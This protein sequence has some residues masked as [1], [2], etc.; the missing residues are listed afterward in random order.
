MVVGIE[1]VSV[2]VDIAAAPVTVAGR[3]EVV[4]AVVLDT[5]VMLLLQIGLIL[6]LL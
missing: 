6:L 2:V 1:V 4:L 5:G 3:T